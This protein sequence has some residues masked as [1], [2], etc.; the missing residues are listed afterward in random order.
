MCAFADVSDFKCRD[1]K[2]F[3]FKLGTELQKLIK[4]F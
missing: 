3:L 4:K 2:M 1:L